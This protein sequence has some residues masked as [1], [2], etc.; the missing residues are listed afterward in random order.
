[1]V[2]ECVMAPST[3]SH[4]F[5]L[6]VYTPATQQHRTVP[7]FPATLVTHTHHVDCRRWSAA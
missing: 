3:K 5:R 6:D 1:V 4:A 2:A 7:A